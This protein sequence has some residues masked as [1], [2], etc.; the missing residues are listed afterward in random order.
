[1][2]KVINAGQLTNHLPGKLLLPKKFLGTMILMPHSLQ[3]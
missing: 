3:L 2:E 1:M